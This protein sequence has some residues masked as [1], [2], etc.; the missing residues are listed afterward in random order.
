[1]EGL[2]DVVDGAE[3]VAAKDV[4]LAAAQGREEDDRRIPRLV[5]LAA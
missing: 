3:L 4:G 1:M 5:A 2:E